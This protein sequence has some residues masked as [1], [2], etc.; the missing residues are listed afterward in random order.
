MPRRV[1]FTL[2][3]ILIAVAV[4]SVGI[5]GTLSALAFGVNAV[6]MGD[7]TS[8]ATNLARQIVEFVRLNA[9][10][11]GGVDI[12]EDT[13]P[14]S[15]NEAD[16]TRTAMDATPLEG[17]NFDADLNYTRNI[18]VTFPNNPDIAQIR[19]RVFWDERGNEKFVELIA[20]QGDDD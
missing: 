8:E 11:I 1:G 14:S 18:Q 15:L 16:S 3:E 4:L 10:N 7:R 9:S 2:V 19:V 20:T 17:L 13:L 12:F 6:K 5:L